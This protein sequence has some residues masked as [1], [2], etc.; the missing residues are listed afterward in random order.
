MLYP[1]SYEGLGSA[2]APRGHIAACLR[3]PGGYRSVTGGGPAG[4][5]RQNGAAGS[6]HLI[7]I[8][9]PVRKGAASCRGPASPHR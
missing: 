3:R 6:G 7:V 5:S 2:E 4:D 8:G 1:L 9:L